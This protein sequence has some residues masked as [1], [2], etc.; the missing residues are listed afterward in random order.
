MSI[1][2]LNGHYLDPE[3]EYRPFKRILIKQDRIVAI[4]DQ[5]DASQPADHSFDADGNLLLPGLVDLNA[6]L[7]EPGSSRNGT[8]ETETH[9]AVAGGVTTLCCRPDTTP[10]NDTKAITKLIVETN[11]SKA[12][13]EVLPV[14][15]MTRGLQGEQLS[16][17]SSL[18]D[19]GCVAL[20]NAFNPIQSLLI[21]QRCFEYARTQGLSVMMNPIEPSLHEGC[22]HEGELSAVIGLHGIPATAETIAVAQLIALAKATGVQLHLSQLSCAGSVTLLQQAKNDGQN[23]TADVSLANLLY[24]DK[25]VGYFDSQY[26]CMPPLRSE[27]DRE[28][29]TKG[30]QEGIID[31]I[32]SGH[33]PLEAA[34]KQK[35]FAESTPGMSLLEVILPMALKLEQEGLSLSKFVH[36]MSSQPAAMLG[37][38]PAEISVG[39]I[40]NLCLFDRDAEY[41]LQAD[42]LKSRGTN[43]PLLGQS[44]TGK[45]VMTICKGKLAYQ[46]EE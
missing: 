22:M 13:C 12:H 11:A 32:S 20:S 44:V 31:A 17:Y 2:I 21:T 46:A 1:E 43:N 29:L 41:S 5:G 30:V 35:P 3:G 7:Q 36:A 40:A 15:A 24:R 42:G 19:A 23:I 4:D 39:A 26:H 37:L 6:H 14:G 9:A 16:G 38:A 10:I 28:A 34:E 25:D 45:V 27:A 18:K 8:I 33:R